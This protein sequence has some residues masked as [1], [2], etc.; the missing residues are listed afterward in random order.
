[1]NYIMGFQQAKIEELKIDAND[2]VILEYIDRFIKSG[3][4]QKEV[5]K[6]ET[7]YWLTSSKIAN[8]LSFLNANPRS[9]AQRISR[10]LVTTKLLDRQTI[11]KNG[12]KRTYYKFGEAYQY[13]V[14]EQCF[15]ADIDQSSQSVENDEIV[16]EVNNKP[17][18]TEDENTSTELKEAP[19]NE[20][21]IQ[22]TI[23]YLN[24]KT[25]SKFKKNYEMKNGKYTSASSSHINQRYNELKKE[26]VDFEEIKGTFK[27]VIDVKVSKWLGTEFETYLR[28]TTLFSKKNFE[29]YRNEKPKQ[30]QNLATGLDMYANILQ[31]ME[32]G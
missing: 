11:N 14:S 17:S 16:A 4:M 2:L 19:E 8:D 29:N 27:Y 21:L 12:G 25:K 31:E 30:Q 9:F 28:P 20:I 15:E 24:A 18:T 13:L 23:D 5:I 6:G 26:G 1:M 10:R 7:Y 32:D 3:N 22:K